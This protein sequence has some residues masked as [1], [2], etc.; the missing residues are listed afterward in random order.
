MRRLIWFGGLVALLW[1]GWWFFAAVAIQNGLDRWLN[2]RRAEGWQADVSDLS[3]IGYP[4]RLEANLEQPVLADPQTGLAFEATTLA[5]QA[6]AYAPGTVTVTF[7][8][9]EILLATPFGRRSV[10]AETAEARL[11]LSAGT[12]AE[13]AHMSLTSGPWMISAPLGILMSADGLKVEMDQDPE[14]GNRYHYAIESPAFQPGDLAR[15]A[16]RLPGDWPKAFDSL[17]L[18]MTVDFDRPFDRRTIEDQRPQPRRIDLRIAEAVWGDLSLRF[19]A[20]LDVAPDGT[21]DGELSIQA[22]NWRT[23]L[24]VAQN[25]GT[26]PESLRPQLENI[27]DALARGGGN[28]DAL[29]VTLT[30]RD[31]TVFLGFIPIGAAPPILI[32]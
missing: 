10:L 30:L 7:P 14:Q 11:T 24:E 16:A 1:S 13:V 26:L 20:N 32:R 12:A 21:P 18:D 2:D 31:G 3:V 25:T 4:L 8:Q 19:S 22:R 17:V 29:D 6:P 15:N 5:V 27:L 9:D 28:V 23:L